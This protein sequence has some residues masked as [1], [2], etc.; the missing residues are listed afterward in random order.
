MPSKVE[1]SKRKNEDRNPFISLDET[2]TR[3][4]SMAEDTK[5]Q[6]PSIESRYVRHIAYPHNLFHVSQRIKIHHGAKLLIDLDPTK[7]QYPGSVLVNRNS[8]FDCSPLK[9]C[10]QFVALPPYFSPLS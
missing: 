5:V 8:L 3:C 1:R 7:N 2:R 10:F 9:H 4:G 6:N